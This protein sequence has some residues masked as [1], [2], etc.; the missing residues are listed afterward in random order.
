MTLHARIAP[1]DPSTAF[2]KVAS[3]Q[4]IARISMT[5][6]KQKPSPAPTAPHLSVRMLVASKEESPALAGRKRRGVNSQH[7]TIGLRCQSGSAAVGLAA[8]RTCQMLRR[9]PFA[10]FTPLPF[11]FGF[12]CFSRHG[13]VNDVEPRENTREDCPQDRTIPLPGTYNSERRTESDPCLSDR[14][15][16]LVGDLSKDH[17]VVSEL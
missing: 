8:R 15:C 1:F 14:G 7:L 9:D 6:P 17:R 16:C 4:S 12:V 13:K 5:Q 3:L 10:F 2:P 11:S